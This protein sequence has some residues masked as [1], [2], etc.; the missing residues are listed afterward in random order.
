MKKLLL[1]GLLVIFCFQGH[2]QTIYK[3]NKVIPFYVLLGYGWVEPFSAPVQW[4]INYQI[5]INFPALIRTKKYDIQFG[6]TLLDQPQGVFNR[7][8]YGT[9]IQ[10]SLGKRLYAKRI[11]TG[12]YTGPA[13]MF[14]DKNL[15]RKT[16]LAWQ[17]NAPFIFKSMEE[18]GL[19]FNLFTILSAHESIYGF[20][21]CL[22]LLNIPK[23]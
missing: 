1:P 16:E 3:E 17:V 5:N 20:S 14:I 13:Y 21:F 15:R 22:S 8:D 7:Q 4:E 6:L 10:L 23:N 9:A 11:L 18:L 2:S 12:I 19:G